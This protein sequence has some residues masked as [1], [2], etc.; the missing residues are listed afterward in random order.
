MQS[1]TVEAI[2][3]AAEAGADPER[4][5]RARAVAGRGLEGDRNYV[6]AGTFY[7]PRKPGRDLTLI[8]AEAIEGLAAET[9]IRL[10]PG[11]ARR[12]VVTRGVSLNSLVGRRFEVGGALCEGRLLCDPCRHLERATEQGVLKGLANR[13]GLRADVLEDGWIEAGANMRELG[14]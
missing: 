1:G 12:N 10:E 5:E 7:D 11:A 9:G 13:G 4:V 6:G 3:I 8:E 14:D 2:Y